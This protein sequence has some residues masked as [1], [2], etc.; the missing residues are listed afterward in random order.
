MQVFYSVPSMLFGENTEHLVYRWDPGA[1]SLLHVV[2]LS[3]QR[4]KGRDCGTEDKP[5]AGVKEF[6]APA[7]LA[8]HIV[9]AFES[10]DPEGRDCFPPLKGSGTLQAGKGADKAGGKGERYLHVDAAVTPDPGL[11]SHWSLDIVRAGAV[12]GRQVPQ[13]ALRRITIDLEAPS[14]EEALF[15]HDY[16]LF[17][18]KQQ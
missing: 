4:K 11:M 1:G 10:D 16:F 3:G 2:P 8:M 18:T 7:F 12:E 14:G 6:R 5:A 9:N 13:S 15:L 17:N